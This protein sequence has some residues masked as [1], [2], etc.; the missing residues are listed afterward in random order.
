MNSSSPVRKGSPHNRCGGCP[1][2]FLRWSGGAG[3]NRGAIPF[4]AVVFLRESG[5]T[6]KPR[7]RHQLSPKTVRALKWLCT[8]PPRLGGHWTSCSF[9]LFDSTR[10][11]IRSIRIRTSLQ[12]LWDRIADLLDSLAML[13]AVTADQLEGGQSRSISR[14]QP[15]T[16]LRE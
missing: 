6:F 10:C 8:P 11:L 7:R 2:S 3:L 1:V 5:R 16:Y 9:S 15:L 12:G 13:I 14:L 4:E